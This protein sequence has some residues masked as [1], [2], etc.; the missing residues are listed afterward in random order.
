VKPRR[1]IWKRVETAKFHSGGVNAYRD[2]VP[3]EWGT[4]PTTGYFGQE[5]PDQGAVVA[6]LTCG[7]DKRFKL[8]KLPKHP[9][10]ICDVC[11]RDKARAAASSTGTYASMP[12]TPTVRPAP[13]QSLPRRRRDR[14]RRGRR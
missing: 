4:K 11:T 10:V 14:A 9:H 2:G 3:Y 7:H 5:R 8:S 12:P 13:A 6:K 1:I